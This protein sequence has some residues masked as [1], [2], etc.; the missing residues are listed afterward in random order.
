M[1]MRLVRLWLQALLLLPL[2]VLVCLQAVGCQAGLAACLGL[3]A[4]QLVRAP[5]SSDVGQLVPTSIVAARDLLCGFWLGTR[6]LGG[7]EHSLWLQAL[8]R[9]VY[10]MRLCMVG[11]QIS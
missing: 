6:F 3:A 11:G 10:E 4:G 1:K 9:H 5:H 2:P 8:E 7:L